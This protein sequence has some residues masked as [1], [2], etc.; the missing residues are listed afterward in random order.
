M[1]DQQSLRSACTYAHSNQ[2]LCKSLKYSMIVKLLTEHH[3]EFLSLKGGC[4]GSSES[5]HVKMPHCWKSHALAQVRMTT[6]YDNQRRTT[7]KKRHRTQ[8]TT[9]QQE[10]KVK[11]AVLFLCVMIEKLE[12]YHKTKAKHNLAH[13]SLG[14]TE[15]FF[16]SNYSSYWE[17]Q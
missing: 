8:T 5:T 2:S 13:P 14:T 6:K 11:Q 16:E 7:I 12:L 17:Q 10:H 3:L 9:R 4:R 1:C 15:G